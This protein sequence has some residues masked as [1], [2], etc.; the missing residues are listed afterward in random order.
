VRVF[1]S[2]GEASGDLYAS[3][4]V[5]ALRARHPDAEFF[6][7]AGPRMQA[8]GVRAVVDSRSLAVAGLV[9]VIPHIPRIWREFRKLCRSFS[10]TRPDI[11]V[12]TDSPDFHLRLAKKLKAKGIPIVYLIAPQAWAWRQGRVRTMRATIQR[13]LC[14]FP[15]E[16][17]FFRSHGVPASFIGHPLAGIVR[18]SMSRADFLSQYNLPAD[19]PIITLLPGSRHGEVAR[20]IPYLLDAAGRISRA[21]LISKKHPFSNTPATFVLALPPGFGYDQSEIRHTVKFWE[22]NEGASIQVKDSLAVHV[23][24]GM[25]WD[26]LAYSQLALAASGTVTVEAALLGTPMVTFYRVNA[27]SWLLGR[28]LVRAPFLSMVNLVAGRRVAPELIQG[29]MTGERIAAEAMR[30]LDDEGAREEM[31]AGLAEVKGKLASGGDP[32]EAAAEWI[33]KVFSESKQNV[34]VV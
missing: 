9:E 31:R 11:A 16:E 5:E 15:F 17:E 27:L 3:R 20:H 10:D 34:P 14:I 32:M 13:L 6:G 4:V 18:P 26:A 21:R 1:I 25:T 2:A 8:A 33:E 28:W 30:L 22:R 29:E 12:L 23:M 19:R 24:E 7:C